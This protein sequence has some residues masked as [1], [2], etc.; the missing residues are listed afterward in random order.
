MQILHDLAYTAGWLI[1]LYLGGAGDY[2]LLG[3][4]RYR[5]SLLLAAAVL[6]IGMTFVFF[7]YAVKGGFAFVCIVLY[8]IACVF[9]VRKVH[10][11]LGKPDIR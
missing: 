10:A 8:L 11:D 7:S 3:A 1:F 6:W 5:A 2:E 4:R 9:L